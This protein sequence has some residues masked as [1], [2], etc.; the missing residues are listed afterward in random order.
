VID[1]LGRDGFVH[2]SCQE[3]RPPHQSEGAFLLCGTLPQA[4]VHALLLETAQRLA[5]P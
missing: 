4:F 2:R 1:E 5:P 3:E